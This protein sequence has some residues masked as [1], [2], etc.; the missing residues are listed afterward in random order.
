MNFL[1][2]PFT[3]G[4]VEIQE[5]NLDRDDSGPYRIYIDEEGNKYESVTSFIGR[6]DPSKEASLQ[7]WK[8]AVGLEE[9]NA[10]SEAAATKG[11]AVH[12]ACEQYIA[13]LRW[14]DISMFCKADFLSI[15][16]LLDAKLSK[17]IGSELRMYSKRLKL[18][19]TTDLLAS[20]DNE[21]SIIDF[22]TSGRIKYKDEIDGYFLQM[23]AYA[24]M[25]YEMYG[26]RVKHLVVIMA[27]D[28][29]PNAY[30]YAETV[31]YWLNKLIELRRTYPA[32]Q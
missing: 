17:V 9:A 27:V 30:E 13:G 12:L 31:G 14:Q 2:G 10:I 7:A 20:W 16:K 3:K 4:D 24:A 26:I 11:T 18:A 25:A 23:A 15:K 1:D 21:I 6:S 32:L 22:K 29:D 8:N 19:G 5:V 28:G